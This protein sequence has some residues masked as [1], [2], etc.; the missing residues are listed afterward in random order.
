MS[1][2][3]SDFMSECT[4]VVLVCN[5]LLPFSGRVGYLLSPLHTIGSRTISLVVQKP[6]EVCHRQAQ[7]MIEITNL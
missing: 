1:G 4:H 5:K 6:S 3:V 7:R 2:L